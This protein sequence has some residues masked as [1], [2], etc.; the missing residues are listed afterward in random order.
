VTPSDGV[1]FDSALGNKNFTLE[2]SI[3]KDYFLY[4]SGVVVVR[5][6]DFRIFVSLVIVID[7]VLL[8]LIGFGG[9]IGAVV[10][11]LALYFALKPLASSKR[12]KLSRLSSEELTQRVKLLTRSSWGSITKAQIKGAQLGLWIDHK[13]AGASKLNSSS[14]ADLQQFLTSKIGD[15]LSVK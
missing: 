14:P 1:H 4:D 13:F 8:L 7:I 3:F 9:L 10:I 15:R 5:I 2:S 6:V 11:Y 12:V